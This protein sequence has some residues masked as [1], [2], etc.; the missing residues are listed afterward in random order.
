MLMRRFQ[1]ALLLVLTLLAGAPAAALAQATEAEG[2]AALGLA[3]RRLG[4]TTRVL[5][6]A[7]HPDDENTAVLSTLALGEG[8]DVAYLSLT[9][10]EGGQNLIGP[11]LQ[12]GLGL[13]R[14]GELLAARRLDGARQFFTRAYDYGFSKS[15][16]EAFSH[17]PRDSL[18]ADVVSVI[19][20]FRPDIIVSVFS[21][22]PND[23]HGQHQAAGIL[24]RAGF[25]A[26]ADPARF[27]HLGAAHQAHALYQSLWRPT[28]D[29]RLHLATGDYD[30]LLGRSHY[31]VA[32][33]SR[34]RHRSQDMGQ[35]EPLGPHSAAFALI[36]RAD[37]AAPAHDTAT[38]ILA[39]VDSTVAQLAARLP[40]AERALTRYQ[41]IVQEA[42]AAF[43]PLAPEALLPL[44]AQ[45]DQALQQAI[46]AAPADDVD[47]RLLLD[48][49]RADLDA[50]L[51]LAAG[52]V[53][54]ATADAP[55]VV[56]GETIRLTLAA[57]NGGA[58]PVTIDALEPLLPERWSAQ[59]AE[60]SG[61]GTAS[62]TPNNGGSGASRVVE[63]ASATSAGGAHATPFA[64]GI[65]LEPGDVLRRTFV[66]QV[67]AT[68]DPDEPY[69]LRAARTGDLYTWPDD[70]QLRG[71]PFESPTIRA[72]VQATIDGAQIAHVQ[73][74]EHVAVDK[75]LGEMRT[76]VLVVPAVSVDITPDV[77]VVPA[78]ST[79][80]RTLTVTLRSAAR[81]T[82]R[83]ELRIAN[84]GWRITPATQPVALPP[85]AARRVSVEVAPTAD[86][87]SA[88][89]ALDAQLVAED[90]RAWARGYDIIAYPHIRPR[91]LYHGA[92]AALQ[93]I[94]V[95]MAPDLLV[96]YIEGAGDGGVDALRQMGA[97]VELLDSAALAT[98]DLGRYDAIVA[99]IRA[100]EVRT[101]LIRH[102]QRLL[103]Y[104]RNGG[105][106]IVQ[107]NKYELVE[108]GFTPFPITMARPHG[109]VTDETA[110]VQLLQ[111][112]HPVLSWPNR[113]TA[114]DFDGWVH[115]RGLYF[116]DTWD[117]AYTPLLAMSDP[118][119]SPLQGSLLVARYSEGYYV[120][121][122]LAFF[123][124][125]PEGVPG[126][127]R[128]FANLVS[129]GVAGD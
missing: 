28:G 19:R 92:S 76:P 9:R 42:Q 32:M 89:G 107:Y 100:Y 85:G 3:L 69:F 12:E 22:T 120:Y 11:E 70:Q 113:I 84:G 65:R 112:E 96:G 78:A 110:P 128:L 41:R 95:E 88:R 58:H 115:E 91:P 45:A 117:E 67:P 23:G 125:L 43:N 54:D 93:I 30:P 77:L 55:R 108:G 39:G 63:D 13:I 6:I 124:Q 49:E 87:G 52:L 27:P 123:R 1:P 57:W 102:N 98:R 129:L 29:E 119:E 83:G 14:S 75:A 17:W 61:T 126:A 37:G 44:L 34:S 86:A 99:G 40:A 59:L 111:P 18:L 72:S 97:R 25:E 20:R 53:I 36:A 35:D 7:A 94:D 90:G 103:A 24:A 66:V 2:A 56:P 64:A 51:R 104:A 16:D 21:G 74:V 10:G 122:G 71:L 48:A 5:M 46:A 8:A 50:A 47:A 15:A 114:R 68:A 127:Y 26:A 73:E 33:A 79:G 62:T 81:D 31:Q 106:V 80:P 121:T 82:I 38:S 109:R 118:G 101:D 60:T 4:T 116:A 105:T